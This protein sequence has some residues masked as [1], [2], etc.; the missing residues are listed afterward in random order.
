MRVTI[1]FKVCHV[2]DFVFLDNSASKKS[3]QKLQNI[4]Q[5]PPLCWYC[6]YSRVISVVQISVLSRHAVILKPKIL[7][8]AESPYSIRKI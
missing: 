5:R 7:A 2:S 4:L 3:F 8:Y 6:K 1:V